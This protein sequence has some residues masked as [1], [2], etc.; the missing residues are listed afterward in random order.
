MVFG[1]GCATLLLS[2]LIAPRPAG[3]LSV[4]DMALGGGSILTALLSEF[5]VGELV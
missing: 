3:F 1:G 2:V 5:T 4:G